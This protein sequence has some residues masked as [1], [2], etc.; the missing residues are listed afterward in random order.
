MSTP[1]L[2]YRLIE[3]RSESRIIRAWPNPHFIFVIM[4][5]SFYGKQSITNLLEYKDQRSGKKSATLGSAKV[6]VTI[7]IKTHLLPTV[8]ITRERYLRAQGQSRK[9]DH[10]VISFRG[11]NQ[12]Y[13]AAHEFL[14]ISVQY[15]TFSA[16]I[17]RLTCGIIHILD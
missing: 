3:K 7:L 10:Q 6:L 5:C 16:P 11:S 4:S 12:S 14:S 8:N 2:P 13:E 1:V 15:I 17:D 9:S